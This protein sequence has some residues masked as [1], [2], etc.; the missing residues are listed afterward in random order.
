MRLLTP[1]LLATSVALPLNGSGSTYL[2]ARPLPAASPRTLLSSTRFAS[3]PSPTKFL[4]RTKTCLRTARPSASKV[5]FRSGCQTKSST[6]EPQ[7]RWRGRSISAARRAESFG[8]TKATSSDRI[9]SGSREGSRS[10]AVRKVKGRRSPRRQTLGRRFGVDRE[11]SEV[12][13]TPR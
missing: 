6:T 1:S 13:G 12:A 9:S 2:L 5:Y 7:D 8:P 10:R 4:R 3:F 11:N